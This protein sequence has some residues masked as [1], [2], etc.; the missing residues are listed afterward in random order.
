MNIQKG[1]IQKQSEGEA[2]VEKERKKTGKT[3]ISRVNEQGHRER[4]VNTNLLGREAKPNDATEAGNQ[5]FL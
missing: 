2:S 4:L 5:G 1:T 3:M